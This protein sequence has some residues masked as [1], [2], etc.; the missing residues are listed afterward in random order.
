[1]FRGS[2]FWTHGGYQIDIST[3]E[4]LNKFCLVKNPSV[5]YLKIAQRLVLTNYI[6]ICIW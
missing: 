5:C 1:M 4:F 6:F 2:F 3:A